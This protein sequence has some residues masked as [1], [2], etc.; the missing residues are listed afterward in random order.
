M[1]RVS[2]ASVMQSCAVCDV[3]QWVAE[4]V[5]CLFAFY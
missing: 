1:C 3:R 5:L 4:V 2:A